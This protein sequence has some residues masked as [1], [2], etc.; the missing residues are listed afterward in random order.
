M[1]GW[2]AI[3]HH[4]SISLLGFYLSDNPIYK[5]EKDLKEL[6]NKKYTPNNQINIA[7]IISDIK[8]IYII[9]YNS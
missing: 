3:Y 2:L 9:I 1:Q 4:S 7:G 8:Y 6:T 5:Y